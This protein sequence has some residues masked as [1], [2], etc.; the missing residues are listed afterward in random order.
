MT[1][2]LF[3]I[4]D[5]PVHPH[6]K[7]TNEAYPRALAT[8][9]LKDDG[10]EYFGAFLNRTA[11]RILIDFLNRTFRLRTCTISIDGTFPVPCTQY[12]AKRC[13]APCVASLC[14]RDEYLEMV[15]LL[16]LFL[17]NDRELLLGELTRKIER[18]AEALNF[19]TAAFFRDILRNVEGYWAQSRWQVWLDDTVDTFE[20][21]VAGD[22]ISIILISQRRQS[23]LGTIVYDFP[24]R[25]D[26]PASRAL[27]DVIGQFYRYHLSREIRVSHDFDRR[28]ALA[29]KLGS[30]FAR[31][32]N[33]AVLGDASRRVTTSRA[34]ART[35]EH[36]KLQAISAT[37]GTA[38]V[39]AE[40]KKIFKLSKRPLRI[41]AFDVAHISATAFAAAVSVWVNGGDVPDDYE[42]WLS[43]QKSELASLKA[44]LAERMARSKPDLIVIDGGRSHLNA[45]LDVISN[46]PGN[47]PSVIAAVKPRGK[48]SSISHFLTES[49]DRVDFDQDSTACRLL[50]RLRDEAHDLANATHRLSRDML[51]FYELAAIVP[52]LDEREREELLRDVGSIKKIAE[53]EAEELITRYGIKKGGHVATEL[54]NFRRGDTPRAVAL[55]V[56][57]RYVESDGAAEDLIPIETR[58]A[59]H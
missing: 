44:F 48:H 4:A 47:R 17:L 49:G 46:I 53:L 36:I 2:Y 22:V 6:I 1:D 38:D 21:D 5:K 29:K 23:T 30:R 41:E 25:D 20:M 58:E 16:R 40:L 15:K 34:L 32:I 56:P 50:K 24:G 13:I 35:K 37:R 11:V 55:I 14:D 33:I 57:I 19:E 12:Y 7:L 10:D 54:E 43:D 52:S 18:A 26:V 28:I 31:K 3:S 9:I 59:R 42:H 51:H 39:R 45:A 27:A 8:R